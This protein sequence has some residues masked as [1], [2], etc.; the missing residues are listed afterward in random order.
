VE[1]E[2]EA[3][4]EEEGAE[5]VAEARGEG[6][7]LPLPAP[8]PPPPPLRVGSGERLAEAQGEG[9]PEGCGDCVPE[10]LPLPLGARE[11][12]RLAL[13]PVGE[14]VPES[15][16]QLVAVAE[17]LA[18]PQLLPLD[19]PAAAAREAEGGGDME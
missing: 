1:G 17:L 3:Q 13:P 11:P 15:L 7:A 19:V 6:E 4:A 10:G 12:L 2:A 5:G 8:P 9:V 16:P 14:G 18:V